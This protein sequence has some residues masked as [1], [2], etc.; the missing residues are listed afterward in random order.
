MEESV[1]CV[2][3][4]RVGVRK[5]NHSWP[6]TQNT[7]AKQGICGVR[8]CGKGGERKGLCGWE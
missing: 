1:V 7:S 3:V 8:L 6:H 2:G 5:W 4:G